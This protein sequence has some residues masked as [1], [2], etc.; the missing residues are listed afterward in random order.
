MEYTIP[1]LTK[2]LLFGPMP[3]LIVLSILTMIPTK[4]EG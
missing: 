1:L 4:K 2:I 3:L